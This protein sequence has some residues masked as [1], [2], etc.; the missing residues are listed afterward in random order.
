MRLDGGI[1]GRVDD[2]IVLRGN[3][4][5][6]GALQAILHRFPEVAEYRIEVDQTAALAALRIEVELRPD[7]VAEVVDRIDEAPREQLLF[8]AEVRAVA[9][10]SLPR[11]EM[12]ARRIVRKGAVEGSA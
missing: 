4:V 9:P 12:K 6:P 5:Y 8:R 3:N 10:G 1:R 2:M 7:A 11:F